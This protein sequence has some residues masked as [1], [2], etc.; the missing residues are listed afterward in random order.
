MM[1]IDDMCF[2][3]YVGYLIYENCELDMIWSRWS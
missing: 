1:E 2:A 3:D